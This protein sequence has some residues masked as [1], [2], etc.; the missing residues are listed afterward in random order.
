MNGPALYAGR[1]RHRRF[2][3]R[4]HAFTYTLFMVLLDVD[5]IAEAMR[6]SPFTSV[7][8]FNWATFDDRDHLGDPARPLRER[9]T[10]DAAAHGVRL[11]AG[12][13]YL[14]THL[15]YLGY[16][17]NPISFY[18]CCAP[19]GRVE[20][21]MAE[22]HN[23]FGD[24]CSYW[25]PPPAAPAPGRHDARPPVFQ[26]RTP[27]VMHVSPF[28]AMDVDYEFTVT[29]P[30]QTLVTHMNTSSRDE[31]AGR[32]DRPYFDATMTL[33][34]RPWTASALHAV[35]LRH[36]WMTVKVIAGIHWE[37]LRLW[38]KGL[39]AYPNPKS[40]AGR[41]RSEREVKV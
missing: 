32:G 9:V 20:H 39:P 35:L 18:Y 2:R 23:T 26:L 3:P 5:R 30:G 29:S 31:S 37:A 16:N 11:S 33:E 14:L 1:L 7:N 15:R 6:V 13:I 27:K 10:S 8:R 22:V 36:P 28:M 41:K 38:A 40:T 21:V 24:Q 4:P 17:F 34:R 25:L 12:P 19:D